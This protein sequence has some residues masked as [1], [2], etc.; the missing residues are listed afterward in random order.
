ME[1]TTLIKHSTIQRMPQSENTQPSR[2]YH[3]NKTHHN[4]DDIISYSSKTV[5]Q[6]FNIFQSM[7]FNYP[8]KCTQFQYGMSVFGDFFV[9]VTE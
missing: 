4:T 6:T 1:N 5:F 3:T 9:Q 7:F 8:H 2:E